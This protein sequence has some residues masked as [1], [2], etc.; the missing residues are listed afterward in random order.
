MTTTTQ[1]APLD[2]RRN[3]LVYMGDTIAFLTGLSFIPATTVLVGLASRLTGD[4]AL[5]GTVAMSW[6]V[7]WLI[8]QLVAARLVHGK[9]RQ[10]PYLVIPSII[11]RQMMLVFALWLVFSGA[12]P[13]LLTVWVLIAAVVV[14]NICDAIAGISWFDM[15][16][17]NL[18]P[19]QRGRTIGLGQLIGS[20][21]GIGSGLIVER[22]LAP[23]GLPFPLNYAVIF[24]CAWIGFMA[25]LVIILFLRENPMSEETV[26]QSHEGSFFTHIRE[27]LRSD[28]V[29]RRLLLSRILTGLENMTAAFYVVFITNRLSLPDSAIGVFSV[30]FIVGGIL[31]VALFRVLAE[32]Y[33][34]RRVIH[35]ATLLQFSAPLLACIVAIYPPLAQ[36]SPGLAYAIFIVILASNGAVGRSAILGFS[37]YTIDRAPARRRAIYVGVFNTLGGVVALSPV[38]GGFFLDA[39][40]RSLGESTG[41]VLMFGAVALC[42]GIGALISFGLPQPQKDGAIV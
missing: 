26:K 18:T 41:Y 13:A 34:A 37:G 27:A 14:F 28:E 38:V 30:A 19:R 33:G 1:A 17:R 8:P 22:L 40:A 35:A 3:I 11:G 42:A 4:K 31:G 39:V 9:H 5:I 20:I 23:G 21:A 25:S 29:Y 32:R 12:A 7:S 2:A 36:A 15:M 16:S 24:V 6:S 10:K